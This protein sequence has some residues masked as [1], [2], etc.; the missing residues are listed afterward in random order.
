[1]EE[2]RGTV[3]RRLF[4]QGSKSEH[5][6]VMLDTPDGSFVLRRIGGNPFS[7][8]TLDKLVG[9][10]VVCH[11]KLHGYTLMIK[12]CEVVNKGT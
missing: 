5:E 8:P 6:A 9:K 7:D 3:V 11:G 2:F 10:N 1:M 12:D 4:G